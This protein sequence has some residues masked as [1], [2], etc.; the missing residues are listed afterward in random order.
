[1]MERAI[2]LIAVLLMLVL[3]NLGLANQAS[4]EEQVIQVH[5]NDKVLPN[6]KP[7]LDVTVKVDLKRLVLDLK[8]NDGKRVQLT[9]TQIPRGSKRT[10]ELPQ[11]R[12]KHRWKGSLTATFLTGETGA[13]NL[14]FETLQV[15]SMGLDVRYDE[16]DL[17]KHELTLRA[18]RPVVHVGYDI[19]G[20]DGS[21][22]G[23]GEW[24]PSPAGVSVFVRWQQPKNLK[25]LKMRLTAHDEEGFT[26]DL[27]LIPWRWSVP[28][29]E[30]IF[31]TGKWDIRDTEAPKLD[32][33]YLLIKEGLAKYGKLLPIKLYI[34]GHTDTVGA[35]DSNQVLSEKRARSIA[36]FL[37]KKG[38]G[39]PIYFQGF[40]ERSLK[41]QTPDE[42]DE[43]QN[44]RAEYDLAA[45]PPP[46]KGSR[47]W[48]RL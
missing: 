43:A 44:R 8:R 27:E 31:E 34:S 25:V 12:E 16:L 23:E 32:K 18:K 19:T 22:I 17:D 48:K 35:N 45:N 7:S 29:E 1:M 46:S 40:G 21:S 39:H 33:S 38:F 20:E 14:Q 13:M 24:K 9:K 5:L 26:E 15:P 2:P 11:E 36:R 37:R 3:A 30:V 10:F 47:Q 6:K 4:A 42:T 41:V 28:H